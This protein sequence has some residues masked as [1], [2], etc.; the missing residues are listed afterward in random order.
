MKKVITMLL[1]CAVVLSAAVIFGG[2]DNKEYPVTIAN[3]TIDAQPE[4]VVVLDAAT[5]DIISYMGY[6]S[7]LAG[8]S[9]SVNQEKLSAAPSVGSA[10][11]PD[12]NAIM[13]TG[14]EIVFAGEELTGGTKNKLE[15]AGIKVIKM[16]QVNSSNDV[17]TNYITLGKILGGNESG[18]KKG[19][20]TYAKLIDEMEKLKKSI[21]GFSGSGALDT[22]CYLYYENDG[23]KMMTSGT[24]GN[25]LMGYTNCVNVA[26][27]IDQ[28]EADVQTLQ[29]A[30]P[31]FIF[32][33]DDAA[34]NAINSDS[35]L[36]KLDA[37]KSGKLLQIPIENMRRPGFT[38]ID[39][40]TLMINFIYNGQIAATPDEVT[41]SQAATELATT[42][43]STTK[44]STTEPTTQAASEPQE[45]TV[46]ATTPAAESVASKYKINIKDLSLKKE[47]ENDN[48]K[49]MQKRLFD[50]GYIDDKENVT[51]YYGEI[52]EQ[53][54]K[55]FQ[56]KNGIKVSGTAN[57]ET[58][59][60]MFLSDA[61]KAN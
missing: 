54:V 26:V 59:K 29:V 38:A 39:T 53:A 44:P 55:D 35:V 12:V 47:N 24:Y 60:A 34:L 56:K 13:Q 40:L 16:Q 14:A 1:A 15:D 28:T 19:M 27:N 11:N 57:N 50:L 52:T 32:Y 37:I 30:N 7:K 25:I 46:P 51:G 4:N 23:L 49:A 6:D 58:L 10:S 18:K 17:E 3:Y 21:E 2:C 48:V 61:K 8:R 36:S 9:D 45:T 33:S 20:D 5:A 31:K 42:K 41:P 43:P 22:I